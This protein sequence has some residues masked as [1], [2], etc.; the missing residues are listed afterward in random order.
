LQL[1]KF[2]P[3]CRRDDEENQKD[4]Q[5]VDQRDHRDR[6]HLSA[7][8]VESHREGNEKGS[9]EN[10][11]AKTDTVVQEQASVS[12]SNHKGMVSLLH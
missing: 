6:G 7:F 2:V 11:K 1:R 3:E 12:S 5:N 9:M 10:E 8:G 4:G